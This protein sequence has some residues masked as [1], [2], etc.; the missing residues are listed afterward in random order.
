M[1]Q[2]FKEIKLILINEHPKGQKELYTIANRWYLIIFY[3]RRMVYR[4][5]LPRL[6]NQKPAIRYQTPS[7]LPSDAM[8]TQCSVHCTK[9]VLMQFTLEVRNGRM[10][11]VKFDYKWSAIKY[12]T[13]KK[14]TLIVLYGYYVSRTIDLTFE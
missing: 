8:S 4:V 13:N 1:W 11:R 14:K 10:L 9:F 2:N 5:L 6:R 3:V 7:F 12:N